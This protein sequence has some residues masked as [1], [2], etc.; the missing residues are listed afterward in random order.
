M[1]DRDFFDSYADVLWDS[2]DAMESFGILLPGL[3]M[4]VSILIIDQRDSN[5]RIAL[6]ASNIIPNIQCERMSSSNKV[7]LSKNTPDL[8]L[9]LCVFDFDDQTD[10]EQD[11]DN[12]VDEK[13]PVQSPPFD[14]YQLLDKNLLVETAPG[15]YKGMSF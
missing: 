4:L 12:I 8:A 9:G 2:R 3:N 14:I 5:V 10:D 11:F 15:W 1:L 6:C 13:Y 7:W